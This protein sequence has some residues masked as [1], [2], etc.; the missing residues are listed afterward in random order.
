MTDFKYHSEEKINNILDKISTSGL[1]SL[2]D[3]EKVILIDISNNNKDIKGIYENLEKLEEQMES[4]VDYDFCKNYL[5]E[6]GPE[7]LNL[8]LEENLKKIKL[9]MRKYSIQLREKYEKD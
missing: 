5:I 3:S 1:S 9:E 6:H 7:K 8:F 4:I 2:S